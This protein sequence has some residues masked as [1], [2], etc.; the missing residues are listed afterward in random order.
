MSS[1]LPQPKLTYE[2]VREILDGTDV[3][4]KVRLASPRSIED[5]YPFA[6]LE[7]AQDPDPRI[8]AALAATRSHDDDL[9]EELNAMDEADAEGR[10]YTKA[11][12]QAQRQFR[13]SV[14]RAAAS[15]GARL[16]FS[17]LDS[18]TGEKA[19]TYF[20][21]D[22]AMNA[23]DKESSQEMLNVMHVIDA[24]R[25]RLAKLYSEQDLTNRKGRKVAAEYERMVRA[26]DATM[27]SVHWT[28]LDDEYSAH[29]PDPQ[30]RWLNAARRFAEH[31]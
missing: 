17:P 1:F 13:L 8:Q 16:G 23:A 7:L 30:H 11:H 26:L 19:I 9:F 2:E 28:M 4:A 21:I 25:D 6:L 18:F 14:E 12:P 20:A 5:L 10:L 29:H 22:H 24:Q 27:A 3:A 15:V 31:K